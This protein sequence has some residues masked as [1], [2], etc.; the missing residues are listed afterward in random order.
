MSILGISRRRQLLWQR[1]SCTTDALSLFS[2]QAVYLRE[3]LWLRVL[4]AM[5]GLAFVT[6]RALSARIGKKSAARW[7][8]DRCD[9]CD[10]SPCG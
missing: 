9:P 2:F 8:A 7:H 6:T 1:R 10:A 4:S 3:G 5:L